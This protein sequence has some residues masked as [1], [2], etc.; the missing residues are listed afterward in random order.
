MT[1]MPILYRRRGFDVVHGTPRDFTHR[2]RAELSYRALVVH[3]T[4]CAAYFQLSA[5]PG[6]GTHS[7]ETPC[8]LVPAEARERN[9]ESTY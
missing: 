5:P 3:G 7:R 6:T 2:P 8:P 1:H 4:R 9:H